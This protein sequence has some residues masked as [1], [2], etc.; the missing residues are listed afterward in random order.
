MRAIACLA[1]SSGTSL[2]SGGQKAISFTC[3]DGT[4]EKATGEPRGIAPPLTMAAPP[5]IGSLQTVL[6]ADLTCGG[7]GNGAAR[8]EQ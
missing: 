5:Q 2:G 1:I 8:G 4:P 3:P 7:H 6:A